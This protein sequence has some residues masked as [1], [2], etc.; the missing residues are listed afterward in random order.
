M[1]R[2]VAVGIDVGSYQIKAVVTEAQNAKERLFPRVLGTGFAEARGLR[3]GYVVSAPEVIRSLKLAIRQAEKSSG[4]KIKTVYL[5]SVEQKE[6]F[7]ELDEFR[8]GLSNRTR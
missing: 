4:Q 7:K 5:S 6:F 2:S 3:H 8:Q 1:S